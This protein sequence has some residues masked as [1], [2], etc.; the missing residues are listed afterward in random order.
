MMTS[1]NYRIEAEWL[2]ED[3][4]FLYG[5]R[6]AGVVPAD[7]L[8]DHLFA[9]HEPSFYGTFIETVELDY[10]AGVKLSAADAFSFFTETP[11]LV[12][13][14]YVWSDTVE[15]LRRLSP[16]LKAALDAGRFMPDYEQWQ[17][18]TL[19]WK[20][21]LPAEA[22]ALAAGSVAHSYIAALA[23]SHAA[24]DPAQRAV[25][26]QLAL[27]PAAH[28]GAT[29]GERPWLDEQD[30]LSAIGWVHDPSPFR[31]CLQLI[32]PAAAS[33]WRF[34]IA[35]QD[36]QHPEVLVPCEADGTP[37]AAGESLP[38][39]WAAEAASRIPRE[40]A[41]WLRLVPQLAGA[42]APGGAE[43]GGEAKPRE[44]WLA[45]SL[46]DD[47]AWEF[48]ALG[49]VRL[50][51]AGVS[52]LLPAWWER[53]RKS[54][55]RLKAKVKSSVGAA[56][57]AEAL[58]GLDGLLRF[59]WRLA[60]G[61][62][63]L[64]E[65]EFQHLLE[66]KKRLVRF[67]GEWVQL[68]PAE[69]EQIREAMKRTRKRK[70][71]TFREALEMHLLGEMPATPGSGSPDS[72][73]MMELEA[74][75]ELSRV[76]NQLELGAGIPLVQTPDEFQ[77]SLRRYQEEGVSWLLFLRK[78]GLG[79]CLADD[80]G[81]GKT[82]QWISYLLNVKKEQEEQVKRQERHSATMPTAPT[83]PIA[84]RKSKSLLTASPAFSEYE[85]SADPTRPA[86][87]LLICPTS[88]LGNWQKEL[89]RFAP[90]LTIHLHY[91]ANRLKGA[92]FV[93][94]VGKAD[95]VLTSYTLSHLDE[96][97]LHLVRWNSICLDE[98]QNIKNAYTKQSTAIRRLT[99]D[100][101]IAM[102]GTPIEN[103]LTELWSIFDFLNPGYLG[104]LREFTRNYVQ[105]IERTG[106]SEPLTRIQRLIKPFLLRREKR[107]PSIL[108]DLP[109]KSEG[110]V[111]VSLT[112]EQASL[113]E[114]H[115]RD[116][117][118]RLETLS[119]MERRG[120]ILAALTRLKQVCDHPTLFLKDARA[121]WRGRSSKVERLIDM[122][123]ELRSEGERCLIFTQF[124]EAGHLLS[125]ALTEELGEEPMF[126]H[127][128]TPK[129][130]RD[131]MINRFQDDSQSAEQRPGIF[132][133]SLKAGGIGLNLTAASHVFHFDR[134]WNPAVENQATDRAYR[135]GQTR[136]VQVHKFVTLGT[137][138]ERIDEM[139]ERKL[140][141]SNQIVG[142]SEN[143][144]TELSTND[145]RELFRLRREWI[146]A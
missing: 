97:E 113:Y 134:W 21:Q 122:V 135:I 69:L 48:L 20:L 55:P 98:A 28:A 61:D 79:G 119:P 73:I 130:A 77:G 6:G 142:S 4:L 70:G 132:L 85:D 31:V 23:H 145:L 17:Q 143:W 139:L 118:E 63:E 46:D 104:P 10:R 30:W 72:Q 140:A 137:L 82:I 2:A 146:E 127:G 33:G 144:I 87:S 38:P 128:G 107:D 58:F 13:A 53:V 26:Q 93:E 120:M 32:E 5:R 66:Q 1:I 100:H 29:E 74:D 86:P 90:S 117:F 16:Y 8:R 36:R 99:G 129:A 124:V 115:I 76:F 67:R 126:L 141:L 75:A 123:R 95:L 7:E 24:A 50:A 138:E 78:I 136:H 111:Y 91:G 47:A 131:A 105:T 71:L 110:K 88:V 94:A 102:T 65:E 56:P 64:T 133:L 25:L 59:D 39:G 44:A 89:E 52:V 12:H 22:Q 57:G 106:Q 109:E 45:E 3:A 84:D 68:D 40:V 92:A 81:L 43:P 11:P 51:E 121:G 112:A 125:R 19:G 80:M 18:G 35:L 96:A 116:M 108:L 41:R 34:G 60:I 9:W 83:S 114:N 14:G 15:D 54:K 101:R 49:A 27:H 37:L 42:A 103:R 62:Q